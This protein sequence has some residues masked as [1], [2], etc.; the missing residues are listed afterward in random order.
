MLYCTMICDIKGS[1]QLNNREEIQYRLID[2]LKKANNTFKDVI[3]S[4]FIITLG[5]EWQG[6]LKYPCNYIKLINFFKEALYD[7][8]FYV[9][10]G[11]GDVI[12]H[13]FELTVNQLDGPCF[14]RAREA[15]VYAKKNNLPL[16]ILYDNWDYI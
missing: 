3:V 2:T 12:I 15:I 9:G 7:I 13:N 5:D 16:T 1:K 10:I 6:L 14:Y 8:K 11:V 4:P